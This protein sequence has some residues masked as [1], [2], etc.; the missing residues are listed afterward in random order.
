MYQVMAVIF[1]LIGLSFLFTV[2]KIFNKINLA[3]EI[4]KHSEASMED[5]SELRLIP[6]ITF[7]LSAIVAAFTLFLLTFV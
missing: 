5:L 2:M 1:I 3:A 7:V 6:I 4:I